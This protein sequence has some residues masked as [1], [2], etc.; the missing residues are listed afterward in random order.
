MPYEVNA[1]PDAATD[2]A[3][4]DSH[5]RSAFAH[6][7]RIPLQQPS[8]SRFVAEVLLLQGVARADP[9]ALFRLSARTDCFTTS[10][11][12]FKPLFGSGFKTACRASVRRPWMRAGPPR[13]YPAGSTIPLRRSSPPSQ[14]IGGTSA[15]IPGARRKTNISPQEKKKSHRRDIH[16]LRKTGQISYCT[17]PSVY[18]LGATAARITIK[19]HHRHHHQH[20]HQ[21]LLSLYTF[22]SR[23]RR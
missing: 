13:Y 10:V 16:V 3:Q 18:R 12:S 6:H 9:K 23:A 19:R 4:P 17:V 15:H 8:I 11:S 22:L 21:Q 5:E 14:K 7:P 2:L 1:V 20:H